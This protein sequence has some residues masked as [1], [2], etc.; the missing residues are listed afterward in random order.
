MAG[1]CCGIF[2]GPSA[3]LVAYKVYRIRNGVW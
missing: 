3:L 1:L 2:L